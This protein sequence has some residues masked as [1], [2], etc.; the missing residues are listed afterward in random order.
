[1][2]IKFSKPNKQGQIPKDCVFFNWCGKHCWDSEQGNYDTAATDCKV[3]NNEF[4]EK[5]MKGVNL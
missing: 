4:C 1:M 2:S 5:Y 3:L